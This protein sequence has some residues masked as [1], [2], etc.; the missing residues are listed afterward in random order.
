MDIRIGGAW[1]SPSAADAYVNGAWRSLQYGEAYISGAWQT[2]A[3]FT[4]PSTGDGANGT[5]TLGVSPTDISGLGV[6]G[7]TTNSATATPNG[8]LAP[9]TYVW[10][11]TAQDPVYTFTLTAP[12]SASTALAVSGLSPGARAS[13]SI[14]CSC[15]DSTGL[16]AVS[17]TVFGDF[18]DSRFS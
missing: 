6:G 3:N 16:T 7:G 1:Q 9:Y 17:A 4:P 15:S 10:T 2:I 8:G 5:L 13:C 18:A 11:I 12:N 14:Q